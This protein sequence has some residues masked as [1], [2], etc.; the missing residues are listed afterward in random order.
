MM[1]SR[2]V[3]WSA[4]LALLFG[5]TACAEEARTGAVAAG[6]PAPAFAA[7]ELGGDTISLA[8]LAGEVVVLNIWA[9]WCPPCR[10]EMP[11]LQELHETYAA[12]GLR[13]VGVSIDAARDAPEIR[14]FLDDNDISF[15]ILHDADEQVTRAFRT[16]GVPE[17]FLIDRE[18]RLVQRWLGKIDPMA[19]SVRGPVR[20]ALG[21]REEV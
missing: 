11:G 7:P 5:A 2:A 4:L 17:T 18:G 21:I 10:E 16:I 19:E 12:H 1:A 20:E 14:R 15:T 3:R 13:V 8:M 6:K 9:T